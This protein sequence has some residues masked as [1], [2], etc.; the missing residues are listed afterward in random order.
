MKATHLRCEYMK[1]PK[2]LDI[3]QPHLFWNCSGGIKQTAYQIIAKIE[4]EI[5]WD[6]KKVS[7][8]QMTHI[9]YAGKPLK[10]RD[11]VEW[12]VYLWDE[13]DK[14]GKC[15]TATFEM[16]LLEETDWQGNWITAPIST[17][18]Y[19]RY[20]ADYFKK[21][22]TLNKHIKR[23]RLYASA[24]GV[25]TIS[26][27]QLPL[28]EFY[29]APGTTDYRK[30]VQYQVYDVTDKLNQTNTI[31]I[32]LG[33]GWYRGSVGCYGQV[34]VFGDKTAFRCQLEIIFEDDSKTI[35]CSDNSFAWSNDGPI[36][37]NDLKDGEVYDANYIPSY[38]GFAQEI[39]LNYHLTASNNV[40]VRKHETFKPTLVIT[41][42]G[43]KVLDFHQNIAGIISFHVHAEK[44]QKLHLRF[45]EILD[46]NGEFTQSNLTVE[47]PKGRIS[48]KDQ[49]YILMKQ[50]ENI[51]AD[52]QPTPLQEILYT[53]NG[54]DDVYTSSFCIF[55]FRYVEVNAEMD[56]IPNDFSAIAIY[57]DMEITGT[58]KCS[59]EKI[60][61]FYQ[62]TVWSMKGNFMDVP[63]D[64]PTR[65]RLA[66]TGDGQIFFKTASY[67]MNVASFYRK[68][69]YD[70]SDGQFAD[71]RNS[72]VV[73]YSGFDM[74]YNNTGGSVGWADAIVL[75]PYRFWKTYFDKR[76]LHT[77]YE[78]MKKYAM[79]VISQ[80]GMK[81]EQEAASNPYNAYTYE[82]GFHLGEWL[83]PADIR[84]KDIRNKPVTTE[85][86]TAYL[87]HTMCCMK[88]IACALDKKD[89]EVLFK[90][91][92]DGSKQA[93]S[94]LFVHN[95]KIDAYQ[96]AK[97][98]RPLAFNL[99]SQEHRK[100]NEDTLVEKIIQRTYRIGTGFLSTPFILPVLTKAGY[101]D[102]AYKM[103]ENE[104]KPGW[105]AEVNEGATT[106]W[107]NWDGKA[108]RNH[109]S[110]GSV[111][112]WLF[113]GVCGIQVQEH[114]HITIA[115]HPGGTLTYAEANYRSLYG[116]IKSKW[117]KKKKLIL[118]E[119]DIPSNTSATILWKDKIYE[120]AAGKHSFAFHK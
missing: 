37:F 39:E 66:W 64:C 36:R 96:Q 90:R 82:K 49:M 84:P 26:I 73:P 107:E 88:E 6:T 9:A 23:A 63:T 108:S 27:N 53:A 28:D 50:T 38:Q 94:Y 33:D 116:N 24:L 48:Q 51:Q 16:G 76:I 42:S 68:W 60:N 87:H 74:L 67:I 104:E 61:R 47:K 105:L 20:P 71:G 79:Y 52:M 31:E 41:P 45:G 95:G 92:A 8:N 25:Y 120:V 54:R 35:I 83:E 56:I 11:F 86:C 4:D 100:I 32:T 21:V 106:V 102:I 7:S 101:V 115:P 59:N 112:E 80:C 19:Q 77:F 81:D 3:L 13:H 118:L 57:S 34:E 12:S 99:L 46:E 117:K 75:I 98:V 72:A 114:N 70:F 14:K 97:Y 55:G 109:Y 22:F 91:Y 40:Y 110:P 43:K 15:S 10:S 65:E 18:E 5:I 62:N 78:E 113:E 93:Y 119:V 103:L 29:L 1:N 30:R 69:M 17:E 111:C 58:F 85:E 89:D 2:G 44:G